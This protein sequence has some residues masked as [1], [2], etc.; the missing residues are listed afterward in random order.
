MMRMLHELHIGGVTTSA[1]FSMQILQTDEFCQARADTH[2]VE[3]Y[4]EEGR[5]PR[6]DFE[7]DLEETAAVIAVLHRLHQGAAPLRR[8]SAPSGGLSPWVAVGR[9]R[10][11]GGR[12]NR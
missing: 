9:G 7:D 4:L 2:F 1:G 6:R 8:D 3:R 11:L 12:A 10:V 5:A